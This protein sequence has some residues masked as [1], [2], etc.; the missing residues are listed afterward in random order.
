LARNKI[1]AWNSDTANSRKGD[2]SSEPIKTWPTKE[3]PR[4]CLLA[5]G[6]EKLTDAELLTI[7]LRVG[8]GTFRKRGSVM[9]KE[10]KQIIKDK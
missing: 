8:S 9:T 5:E 6:P 2:A 3:S 10:D 7:I 1:R 4:E